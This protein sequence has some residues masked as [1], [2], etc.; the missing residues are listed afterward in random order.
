MYRGPHGGVVAV[1][2]RGG[3]R[4]VAFGRHGGYVDRAYP[5]R[6]HGHEYR[7]RSYWYGGRRYAVA[8]RAYYWGGRPYYWYAPPFYWRPAFYGWAFNP[9]AVP[10]AYAWGWAGTPW[11]GFYAG[12]FTPYPVYASANLWLTD[13]ILAENLRMAYEAQQDAAAAAAASDA[14]QQRPLSPEA[15]ALIAQE[16]KE[17][18]AAERQAAAG[19][20]SG[21]PP[22][23]EAA[24]QAPPALDPTQR[25]FIVDSN[26]DITTADGAECGVTPGDILLRTGDTL[27]DGTKVGVSVQSSKNGDCDP[28]S[29]GNVE[30]ADLQEMHNHFREQMDAGLKQLADNQGKNGLPAAPDTSTVASSDVPP[31][32]PDN[33]VQA[34][35]QGLQS[36]A[37]Q[38]EK[39]VNQK[40][41]AG[42]GGTK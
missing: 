3:V 7:V 5:G 27:V 16:V 6:W 37:D 10:V 9:W 33:D 31:V 36:E 40:S 23:P 8:Y 14:G 41:G 35:V 1:R 39:D 34:Q 17:Q 24:N 29:N 42:G 25:V 11:F 12:Y 28:G 22:P 18:L 26:L 32:Q 38:A 2:E 13:Y 4:T 19:Q 20:A 21:A 15:K 30:V